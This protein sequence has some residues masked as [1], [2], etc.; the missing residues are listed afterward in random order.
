[1]LERRYAI[2]PERSGKLTIPAMQLSGRLIEKPSDRLWQPTVRGR[3]VRI[4]SE[5]LTLEISPRPAGFTGDFWLPARHITLSQQIS[6]SEKLR[7]GEPVTRTVILDAVGLEE[8]MLEE[9]VW[10]EVP[11]TRIYPDQP[12]GISRDD[13]EWVLGHKEFRYAVVP[14]QAGELVLPELRL[15]WW[16]TIADKQRTAVLPEHRVTVLP[17]EL[18]QSAVAVPPVDVLPGGATALTTGSAISAA[19]ATLWK[20][21]TGAFAFLWLITLV[22]YFRRGP[23]VAAKSDANGSSHTAEKELLKQFQHACNKGDVSSARED[24]ARWVRNYAPEGQRGSMRKFG[25]SCGDETLRLAIAELDASG[26]SDVSDA[27][28][29]GGVLWN[30]FKG[31]L[32]RSKGPQKTDFGKKPDL[33]A[34]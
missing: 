27:D 31:W 21:T 28:W 15:D 17:S 11:A 32:K 33:Y 6:D 1:V 29:K 18:A 16:D 20:I 22:L 13:G 12:Q 3:R 10:P 34:G 26:F 8:N 7:V 25:A 2:F 19:G 5:P 23:V 4:E 14:E 9:P 24:F 30:A